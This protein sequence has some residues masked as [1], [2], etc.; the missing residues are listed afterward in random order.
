MAFGPGHRRRGICR[1][2]DC[3]VYLLLQPWPLCQPVVGEYR[4]GW[5][6]EW[7]NCL[8]RFAIRVSRGL[9]SCSAAKLKCINPIPISTTPDATIVQMIR[10][11]VG[12]SSAAARSQD[13]EVFSVIVSTSQR[14]NINLQLHW[15]CRQTPTM[16]V[17]RH[18][19]I[20]IL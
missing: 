7:Q 3:N 4:G 1:N 12:F 6:S 18:T 15:K 14:P 8:T 2:P 20:V 19:S 10:D 5:P 9:G 11:R 16:S 17:E 13:S